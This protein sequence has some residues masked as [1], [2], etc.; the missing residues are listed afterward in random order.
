M[1][2]MTRF[3]TGVTFALLA[4]VTAVP[5]E[6]QEGGRYRV[7]VPNL[8][9]QNGARANFGEDVADELRDLI[10]DMN[11]HAP[12]EDDEVRTALRRFRIDEDELDCVRSRQLAVQLGAELV[13]CGTYAP[14]ADR[15]NTVNASFI[16]AR[17]GERF[18]VPA[19]QASRDRDA[20]Q[21]IFRSFNSYVEQVRQTTFCL[22]YLG[23]QQ[24]Q[25]ALDIC[26][27][28]LAANDQSVT[29]RYATARAR[30]GLAEEK[31]DAGEYIRAEA[32]RTELLTVALQ[33]LQRVIELNPMHQ[34]AL[35]SAGFVATRLGQREVGLDYYR[36]YLELNPGAVNV[37]LA[38]AT[39]LTNAGNPEGALALIEQG[40]EVAGENADAS[41]FE[42]AGHFAIGAA[43][44]AQAMGDTL[45]ADRRPATEL[46][47]VAA[48]Y[49]RRAIDRAGDSASA[50]LRRNLATALAATEN[51]TE[52]LSVT[53]S[54]LIAYPEDAG[55]LETHATLL[56]QA[57]R[58]AEAVE[59]LQRL[60]QVN[61]EA[62]VTALQGLWL[63]Q[64]GRYGE[65]RSAFDR[66]RA[67][68]EITDDTYSDRLAYLGTE[69]LRAGRTDGA[70]DAFEL[71]SAIAVGDVARARGNYYAGYALLQRGTAVEAPATTAS[72]RSALP[73]FR[74]AADYLRQ[75]GA[76]GAA[77]PSANLSG[78]IDAVNAYIARQEQIIAAG[79]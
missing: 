77:Q 5:V 54:G 33:D 9:P 24:Y 52:A 53:E 22:D 76:F 67:S 74:R 57:G 65:A 47:G 46:F 43:S 78:L 63:A 55:L 48:D 50:A 73:I 60:V 30:L 56:N 1:R 40:I 79:R 35:Q 25:T 27:Q 32:E 44:A 20:A 26:G 15:S 12:V 21:Q 61:P 4:L 58:T 34:E 68:G 31:N 16:A 45:P 29:A 69:A 41:L 71:S 6:A 42:Y 8:E 17:T 14:A 39:D 19:F 36:Q 62:K 13:M 38:I 2:L 11:T 23:S 66:A 7:L 18:E 51:F 72:A 37:R 70:V 75:A 28:A 3:A 64:A 49:Y 59:T 10:N